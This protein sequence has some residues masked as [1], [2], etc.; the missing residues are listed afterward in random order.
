MRK[1]NHTPEIRPPDQITD[2]VFTGGRVDSVA[3]AAELAAQGVTH[4]I[5][6][7]LPF[8]GPV[9]PGTQ[10][11]AMWSQ[12][13]IKYLNNPTHDDFKP[14]DADYF[15]R[16]LMFALDGIEDGGKVY[17]HCNMGI[18]RGPS[19]A[20]AILRAQ[21]WSWQAAEKLIRFARPI[22]GLAYANDADLAIDELYGEENAA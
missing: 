2:V 13:G 17:C 11:A 1:I 3:K 12:V 18:N 19:T 14:K 16:S 6:N 20:Y 8:E 15:L 21:G 4:V 9:H 7:R 10:A 22:V 5:D